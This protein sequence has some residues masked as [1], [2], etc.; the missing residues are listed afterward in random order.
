MY[1]IMGVWHFKMPLI[2]HFIELHHASCGVTVLRPDGS[3]YDSSNKIQLTEK[4]VEEICPKPTTTPAPTPT[5]PKD[6]CPRPKTPTPTPGPAASPTPSTTL[7]PI[8]SPTPGPAAAPTP[9]P[10][11]TSGN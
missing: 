11:P 8:P 5:T 1:C 2:Y 3:E 4:S 10:S 9:T 7:R 6:R